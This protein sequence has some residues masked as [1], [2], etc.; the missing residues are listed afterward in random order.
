M[1]GGDA[2]VGGKCGVGFFCVVVVGIFC[3]CTTTLRRSRYV[4]DTRSRA[5]MCA[6]SL[7]SI[8]MPAAELRNV[9]LDYIRFVLV[10]V[11]LVVSSNVYAQYAHT[12]LI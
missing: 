6:F 4:R 9:N 8:E 2:G 11:L 5:L 12:R 7:H 10:C 3:C 1:R